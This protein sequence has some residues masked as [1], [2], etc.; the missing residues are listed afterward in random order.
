MLVG[1]EVDEQLVD[2]V[3]D[4]GRAGVAAVD[5]V[6]RHDDGQPAR[7]RLLEDVARL[8]KRPLG[9]VDEEQD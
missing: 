4:L 7:H 9:G 1:A 8:R 2:G 3:E 5:L 6:E